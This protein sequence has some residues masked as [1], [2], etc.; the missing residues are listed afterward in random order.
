M[1]NY[2]RPRVSISHGSLMPKPLTLCV[3]V[4]VSDSRFSATGPQ[5]VC[6]S[7]AHA[8]GS[9]GF[10]SSPSGHTEPVASTDLRTAVTAAAAADKYASTS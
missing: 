2:V 5:S 6:C 1:D 10:L 3:C 7:D 8:V 9:F 4:C